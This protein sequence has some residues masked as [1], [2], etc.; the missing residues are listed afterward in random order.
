MSVLPHVFYID[1]GGIKN[2]AAS[3]YKKGRMEQNQNNNPTEVC[4]ECKWDVSIEGT[5][6][7][8]RECQAARCFEC[9][10]GGLY[11]L[12]GQNI[13]I[14]C[15]RCKLKEDV[16]VLPGGAFRLRRTATNCFARLN[17]KERRWQSRNR[18]NLKL[19]ETC[20]RVLCQ[21]CG[22]EM[23]CQCI[24]KLEEQV[25]FHSPILRECT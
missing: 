8:C 6:L 9:F 20:R 18:A 23:C 16:G 25:L 19:C 21:D 2:G 7:R 1:V 14:Q 3:F 17:S 12:K 15:Q 10:T 13:R 11:M 22:D 24:R 4:F 5:K